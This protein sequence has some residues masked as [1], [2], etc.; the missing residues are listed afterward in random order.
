MCCV[1]TGVSMPED[2]LSIVSWFRVVRYMEAVKISNNIKLAYKTGT[3]SVYMNSC[4]TAGK[5]LKG[6]FHETM[7]IQKCAQ[8]NLFLFCSCDALYCLVH[9]RQG[10][11]ERISFVFTIRTRD[12]TRDDICMLP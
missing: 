2:T 7:D 3:A 12:E 6:N 11:I 8:K 9:R 5:V 4:T 10:R 1:P